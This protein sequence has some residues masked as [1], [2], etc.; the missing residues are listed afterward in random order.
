MRLML[1]KH[2]AFATCR[3]M[4]I[5]TKVVQTDPVLFAFLSLLCALEDEIDY[6]GELIDEASAMG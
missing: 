4:A 6:V 3:F 5:L 2:F 1:S